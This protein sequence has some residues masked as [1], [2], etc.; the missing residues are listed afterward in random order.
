MRDEKT[1]LNEITPPALAN[2]LSKELGIL[3]LGE[4][5]DK[6]EAE[7]AS[8]N[9]IGAYFLGII[10]W[11]LLENGFE[12]DFSCADWLD[13]DVDC[14]EYE[15]EPEVELNIWGEGG[16]TQQIQQG[17]GVNEEG[18]PIP[19][20]TDRTRQERCVCPE[21]RRLNCWDVPRPRK[22]GRSYGKVP[23]ETKVEVWLLMETGY[24]NRQICEL[25]NLTKLA[26][27][28]LRREYRDA[29]R[30]D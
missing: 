14:V 25:F 9:G 17:L 30:D 1:L 10:K 21:M 24:T 8:C 27:S 26:A 22:E 23:A 29:R 4:L 15:P 5:I 6:S 3:T 20:W 2:S 18:Q 12:T 28:L 11:L 13:H 16:L 19:A 7:I